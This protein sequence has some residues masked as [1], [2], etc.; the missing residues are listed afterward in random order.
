MLGDVI[1][2]V[3]TALRQAGEAGR[4]LDDELATLLVH[5]VLHLCGYDHERN[6]KEAARMQRRERAL[7]NMIS[8]VPSVVIRRASQKKRSR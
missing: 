1:I 3:P 7:R 4:S 6:E 8:P 5:G 2:S